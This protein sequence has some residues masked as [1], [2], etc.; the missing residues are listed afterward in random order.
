M[1]RKRDQWSSKV[2]FVL[3]ASGSAI[4]LGN[5]VFFGARAYQY[6]AG[7]FYLPYLLALFVVGIPLLVTEMGLGSLSGKSLPS[8]LGQIG[9]RWGEFAGW[10][11]LANASFVTVYYIAILGWV[12]GMLLGSL[13]PLWHATTE[14]PAFAAGSLANPAGYFFAMLSSPTVILWV[15]LAWLL[16]LAVVRRGV[17]TIEPAVK[18]FVPLMWIFML[19]LIVRGLTLPHGVQGVYLLFTPD[20]EVMQNAEI[21][22][23][24]VSQ[25]FFSLTLGFGVM[26]AYASYLPR[27]ADQVNN[28]LVTGCLNCGFEF[29]AGVAI[30]TLLFTFAIVPQASTLAMIFFVLP[31]GIAEL[32]AAV[33]LFGVLFFLLLLLAGLS[34]SISLIEGVT[35][36]MID[37]FHWPRRKALS[38]ACGV[39]FLGSVLFSLPMVVDRELAGNGTL[40]LSLLDLVDHWAF[41]HGLLIVG[42]VEALLIGWGLPVSRLREELN[43]YG[44]L[45]LPVAFDWLVKMVIPV[46]LATLLGFAVRDKLRDGLYGATMALDGWSALPVVAF[47]LWL[48]GTTAA[49]AWLTWGRSTATLEEEAA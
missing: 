43:G 18:L 35:A 8:S 12:C 1:D 46:L 32:P 7:A 10:W 3:A 14:V 39:G 22:R 5:I 9:G 37:K 19:V 25:I 40:G 31:R 29:V 30:F 13:G 36:G 44:V 48:A 49:A 24:A 6:G 34:S 17:Q 33:A 41:S 4:G 27:D 45:R 16:N 20:F 42:L 38:I 47:V 2:G 26:T 21:W 23:G 15:G 28:A 11:A